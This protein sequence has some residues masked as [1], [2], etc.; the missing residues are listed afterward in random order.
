MTKYV[1]VVFKNDSR[2]FDFKTDMELQE[3]DT[4]VCHTEQGLSVGAVVVLLDN[5]IKATKWVVDRVNLTGHQERLMREER[6]KQL[7]AQLRHNQKKLSEIEQ[8][9]KLA[10]MHPESKVLL[11][12]LKSLDGV[13]APKAIEGPTRRITYE[14]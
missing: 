9:S 12:E 6:K 1:G 14:G 3:G 8:F 13:E 7:I 10:E 11:E 5:S 4:V 2:V